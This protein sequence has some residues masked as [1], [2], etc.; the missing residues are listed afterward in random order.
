MPITGWIAILVLIVMC[1]MLIKQYE[2]RMVLFGGGFILCGISLAPMAGLNA[3]A[4]TMTNLYR[5]RP[6][7]SALSDASDPQRRHP[8]DSDHLAA[9]LC[10]QHRYSLSCRCG[11]RCRYDLD[12]SAA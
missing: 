12:S 2:T 7:L 8:D 5:V 6:F 4:K 11:R 10:D 1:Y 3:F 9:Y